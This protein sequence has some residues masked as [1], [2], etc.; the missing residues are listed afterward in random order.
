M[1]TEETEDLNIIEI[2]GGPQPL[3]A[4]VT[5]SGEVFLRGD[6]HPA[7]SFAALMKAAAEHIPYVAIS[8]VQVLFPS[9]WLRSECLHDADRQRVIDNMENLVRSGR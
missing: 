7:G 1:E 6:I 3:Y 9:N 4:G 2:Q 5:D 8:A